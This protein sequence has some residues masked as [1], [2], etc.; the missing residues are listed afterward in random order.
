[1]IIPAIIC[2]LP[3]NISLNIII[4]QFILFCVFVKR[5]NEFDV[6]LF[7]ANTFLIFQNMNQGFK[8][9]QIFLDLL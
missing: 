3:L 5:L 4:L 6:N 1:M 8:M 2:K 7:L 9:V